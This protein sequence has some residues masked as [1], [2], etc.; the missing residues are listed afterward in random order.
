MKSRNV[1]GWW[2]LSS[3]IFF[4][5]FLAT[6]Y[7]LLFSQFQLG[8]DLD[9]SEL[10]WALK[11][12]WWQSILSA[13]G[14]I[15]FALILLRG[16]L[17]VPL[18]WQKTFEFF[19]ILPGLLPALFILLTVM[20]VIQ[21]F[22]VGIIGV[23]L[24]HIIINAG[25]VTIV[26][27]E[28]FETKLKTL[29]EMAAVEGVS[30]SRFFKAGF[31]MVKRDLFSIFVFVFALC[32]CSFSVPLVAGGGKATALEVLIYEKIRISGAWSE[33]LTLS[34]IQLAIIFLFSFVHLRGREKRSGR[35]EGVEFLKSRWAFG[36]LCIYAFGFLL[37]FVVEGIAGWP[38]V[39]RIPGLW[40]QAL[41]LVPMTII[42]SLA[43]GIF[44]GLLLLLSSQNPDDPKLKRLI[45]GFVSP[46]TALVGFS[47]LFFTSS[48]EPWIQ[49]KWVL[50]FSYLVFATLYR[51]GWD[52]ELSG[53][54]L[55]VQVAKTMG[56]SHGLVF[57]K[58]ILPQVFSSACRLSTVAAIWALGDFALGKIIVGQDVTLA[59]LIETLLSS[60]RLDSAMA[61][62]S[63]L[64]ILGLIPYLF[65]KGLEYVYRRTAL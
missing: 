23:V 28:L 3:L 36:L 13:I 25:L 37:A 58:I 11:N 39:F 45:T 55:Q 22:P 40:E 30:A 60:Y 33:A 57:Q 47:L 43:C 59:M 5:L 38:Q 49:I 50:G 27:R 19:L 52:Q 26:L 7:L 10:W 2:S 12:S 62:L 8:F 54:S 41:S 31:G 65:F 56:A 24:I 21:P 35:F 44:V 51:W 53:L 18:R 64:L 48:A 15:L 1:S 63:A 20:S 42:F 16:L 6:P 9:V 32:F 14:T 17:T 4:A 46:S 61:L 29:S 34:L